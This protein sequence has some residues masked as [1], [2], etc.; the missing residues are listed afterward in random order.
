[1][2]EEL[3]IEA[4][5]LTGR[6]MHREAGHSGQISSQLADSERIDEP[7]GLVL[8]LS[9]VSYVRSATILA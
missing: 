8:D 7:T 5:K 2:N 9:T 1:M 6:W 4:S 3:D